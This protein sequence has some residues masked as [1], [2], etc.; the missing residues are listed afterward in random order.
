[1]IDTGPAVPLLSSPSGSVIY[2]GYFFPLFFFIFF[3]PFSKLTRSAERPSNVGNAAGGRI[4]MNR[5]SPRS[6]PIRYQTG[7]GTH[8]ETN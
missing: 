4:K 7:G 5:D 8:K 6:L 3:S 2:V 1:M